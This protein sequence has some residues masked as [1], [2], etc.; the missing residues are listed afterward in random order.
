MRG[1]VYDVNKKTETLDENKGMVYN[2][3]GVN[4]DSKYKFKVN[5]YKASTTQIIK[6]TPT[7]N[8]FNAEIKSISKGKLKL[9]S[10]KKEEY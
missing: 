4:T 2:F 9:K 5:N 8:K 7:E 3:K 10:R 1:G 6:N